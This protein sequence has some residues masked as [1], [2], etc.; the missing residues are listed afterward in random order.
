VADATVTVRTAR[1]GV[2]IPVGFSWSNRTDLA[3]GSEF[4]GHI[5]LSFDS[6]PL[7]LLPRLK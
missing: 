3:K 6:V 1:N 4:R 2:K 5:G 7:L